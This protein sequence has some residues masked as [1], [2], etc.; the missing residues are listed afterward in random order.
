[1]L[2]QSGRRSN[3]EEAM[4]WVLVQKATDSSWDDYQRDRGGV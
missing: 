2:P 3:R 1:M 4:A